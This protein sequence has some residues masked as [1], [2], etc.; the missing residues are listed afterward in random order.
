MDTQPKI[1]GAS[2]V[3]MEKSSVD[4]LEFGLLMT[5]V[6]GNSATKRPSDKTANDVQVEI[7]LN[8]A[9]TLGKMNDSYTDTY[10]VKGTKALYEL[11]GAIYGY[12]LQVNESPLRDNI[13]QK[14][15][16]LLMSNHEIK[17]QANT[18][19]ITTVIRFILPTDRQTAYNYAKV[20][21][22]AHDENLSAL[23]LPEYIKRRGGISKIT[24][25]EDDLENTK[26]VKDHKEQK[27]KLLKKILLATAK[28]TSLKAEVNKKNEIDIIPEGKKEGDFELA[29]CVNVQGERRIVRFLKVSEQ[30][31]NTVLNAVASQALPDDLEPV[32]TQLDD[33]RQK[34]G[35]TSG[36]GMEPGDV[37]YC[38]PGVPSVKSLEDQAEPAP[39]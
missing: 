9:K 23:D 35:I 36:W 24:K 17:T 39:M 13:L 22:V 30:L 29:V 4:N 11:L 38:L 37:G 26:A 34:L 3:M 5:K 14:M 8:Q 1:N 28:N 20:L 16:E 6:M 32:K 12:A 15:R 2:E 27:L 10:V 33:F 7:I 21:Q 18:P 31:E 25:T 19:W